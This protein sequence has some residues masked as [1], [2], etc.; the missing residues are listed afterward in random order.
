M[1]KI[2]LVIVSVLVLW[3]ASALRLGDHRHEAY[4]NA[5]SYLQ[6]LQSQQSK[7]EAEINKLEINVDKAIADASNTTD[8]A[9]KIAILEKGILSQ[10]DEIFIAS[11]TLIPVLVL[12][13]QCTNLTEAD[14]TKLIQKCQSTVL[15]I[16][17]LLTK[18]QTLPQDARVQE[19]QASANHQIYYLQTI[20]KVLT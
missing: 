8:I 7:F 2:Q 13:D 11:T 1:T 14:K 16:Q 12:K 20:Q 15:D 6:G 4:D 17:T 19:M 10:E 5:T 9:S 3:S 18:L